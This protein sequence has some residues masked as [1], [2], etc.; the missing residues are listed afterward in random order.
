MAST[1]V[2][3]SIA[4]IISDKKKIEDKL[5]EICQEYN[6]RKQIASIDGEA[7][8]EDLTV[9][10]GEYVESLPAHERDYARSLED[11]QTSRP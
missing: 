10:L 2:L 7:F 1:C 3:E 8:N 9:L 5:I 11:T 4:N 6:I